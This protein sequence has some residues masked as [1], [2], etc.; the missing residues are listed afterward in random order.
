VI[1]PVPQVDEP[2][3]TEIVV[4]FVILADAKPVIMP[5]PYTYIVPLF[6]MPPK[7]S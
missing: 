6:K 5:V 7:V 2:S 1:E 4:L 3:A